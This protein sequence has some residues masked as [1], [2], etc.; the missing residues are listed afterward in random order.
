MTNSLSQAEHF[1]SKG[2]LDKAKKHM[3]DFI[4][5]LNNEPMQE[6]I[7]PEAKETIEQTINNWFGSWILE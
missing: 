7:S 1:C 6:H 2:S 3:E 4:R 5:H